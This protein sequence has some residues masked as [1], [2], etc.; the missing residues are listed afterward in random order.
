ME[1][2]YNLGTL[3]SDDN[4]K[5]SIKWL[6]LAADNGFAEAQLE[7]GEKYLTGTGVKE[8]H[9]EA[10][11]LIKLAAEPG[12]RYG[13]GYH[14]AQGHLGDMFQYGSGVDANPELAMKWHRLAKEQLILLAKQGNAEGQ[15]DLGLCYQY[16]CY[17]DGGIPENVKEAR[18]WYQFAA[19]QG[20]VEAQDQ[21]GEFLLGQ[22][23]FNDNLVKVETYPPDYK[24][25]A[26]W[27]RLAAEW[28]YQY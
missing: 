28:G 1:A 25:A 7:L 18:K 2:Q 26:K 12:T 21:L 22:Y 16:G 27:F 8:D 17:G 20:D 10:L 9:I 13:N 24:E 11:R 14:A 15:F 3:Y 6:K 5:E 19:E 4:P 23:S